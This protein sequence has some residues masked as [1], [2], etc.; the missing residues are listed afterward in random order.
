MEQR[1]PPLQV[2]GGVYRFSSLLRRASSSMSQGSLLR[3]GPSRPCLFICDTGT[4]RP[5]VRAAPT[6][7]PARLVFRLGTS[8]GAQQE[9]ISSKMVLGALSA[10][11]QKEPNQLLALT[12]IGEGVLDETLK[13]VVPHS[14]A[15]AFASMVLP[16]PGGPTI[17]LPPGSTVDP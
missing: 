6:Y 1:L 16:V 7:P 2:D 10:P 3:P 17:R 15:T 14:V 8:S 13:K 4:C 11:S 5:S 9:S 12:C